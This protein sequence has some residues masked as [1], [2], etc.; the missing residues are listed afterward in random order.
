MTS[1]CTGRPPSPGTESTGVSSEMLAR[2]QRR[3]YL[4]MD[5]FSDS[6]NVGVSAALAIDR[7]KTML[8]GGGEYLTDDWVRSPATSHTL[9]ATSHALAAAHHHMHLPKCVVLLP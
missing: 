2:C 5:G 6:F 7:L 1:H 3:V 4:P 9:T 8:G